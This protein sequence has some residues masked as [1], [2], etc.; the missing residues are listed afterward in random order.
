LSRYAEQVGERKD[1]LTDLGECVRVEGDDLGV[2]CTQLADVVG[3]DGADRAE[4]LGQDQ[5][6]L[7]RLEQLAIDRVQRASVADRRAYGLVYF[8]AGKAGR[9]DARSGYD[10]EAENPGRPVA[11]FRNADE[12]VDEAEIGDDFGGARKE[13]TDPHPSLPSRRGQVAED[14]S[15]ALDDFAALAGELDGRPPRANGRPQSRALYSLRR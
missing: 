11:L 3:G 14:E 6:G 10:R 12:R 2:G 8:Q 7:E 1:P 15:V 13:R 4:V 5:I 9:V